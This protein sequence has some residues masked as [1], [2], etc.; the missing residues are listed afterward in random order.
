MIKC[1][2]EIIKYYNSISIYGN[3]DVY[4]IRLTDPNNF[5]VFI[6]SIETNG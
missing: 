6:Q 3:K 4:A 2:S 5:Q 1:N